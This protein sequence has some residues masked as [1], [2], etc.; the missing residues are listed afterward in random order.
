MFSCTSEKDKMIES[1]VKLHEEVQK[2]NLVFFIDHLDSK[3]QTFVRQLSSPKN[4]REENIRKLGEEYNLDFWCAYYSMRNAAQV[5]YEPNSVSFFHYLA[6]NNT[7]L[8]EKSKR[9]ELVRDKSRIR[10][11]KNYVVIGHLGPSG[12]EVSWLNYVKEGGEYKL[13]LLDLLK[14]EEYY[15]WSYAKKAAVEQYG[16]VLKKGWREEQI[17]LVYGAFL[18]NDNV[19]EAM[20]YK[21]PAF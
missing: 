5:N 15:L 20:D 10:E 12:R 16:R 3:S 11:D 14:Q 18:T 1:F 17:A 21:K 8:F 2:G 13:N 4:L 9:F 7:P 19:L 6:M